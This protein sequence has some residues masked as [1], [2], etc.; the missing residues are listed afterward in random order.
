MAFEQ[1]DHWNAAM[2]HL[3]LALELLDSSDAPAI[4]GA[5]LDQAIDS[6]E[7]ELRRSE[8]RSPMQ[9]KSLES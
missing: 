2:L 9:R 8:G 4:V 3:R 7:K 5:R 6:L 1:R